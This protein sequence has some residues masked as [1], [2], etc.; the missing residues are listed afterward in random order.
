[1]SEIT[2]IKTQIKDPTRCNIEVDGRFYCGMK[3]ETVVRGGLKAGMQ[4]SAEELSRL[5]LDSERQTALDKALTHISASMKTEREVRR[6]LEKKGYL[7]DVISYVVEKMKEYDYLNDGEY[8]ARYAE[9]AKKKKGSRLIAAELKRRGVSDEA[10][11]NALSSISDQGESAR[12]VLEKYLRG[13]DVSD[14]NTL[15][16]AYSHLLSKGFDHETARAAL[17]GLFDED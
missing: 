9:S 15:R 11:A 10:I 5:Q 2:A 6:F 3:L 7:A 12:A 16:K 1:M 14:R 8:A 17:G 13:K 4:I